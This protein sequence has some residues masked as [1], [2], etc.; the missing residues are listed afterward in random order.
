MDVI[1][2]IPLKLSTKISDKLKSDFRNEIVIING[3]EWVYHYYSGELDY[4]TTEV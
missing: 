3:E 2:Y 1:R 4:E